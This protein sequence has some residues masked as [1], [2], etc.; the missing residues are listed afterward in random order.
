M[1]GAR[2]TRRG[3]VSL[4]NI[5]IGSVVVTVVCLVSGCGMGAKIRHMPQLLTLK[6]YSDE[7]ARKTLDVERQDRLFSELLASIREET[8]EGYTTARQVE[9]RFGPPV[10]VRM[11]EREGAEVEEW[12]Y[13]QACAF[14]DTDKVYLYVDREGKILDWVFEP[15]PDGLTDER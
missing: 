1:K 4:V 3:I 10:F 9:R 7:G 12:L 6:E 15:G 13:R 8:F 14:K 11:T 5:R 2:V